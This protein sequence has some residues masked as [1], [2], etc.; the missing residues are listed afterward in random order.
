MNPVDNEYETEEAIGSSFKILN[1]TKLHL[2][3]FGSECLFQIQH[4]KNLED[5]CLGHGNYTQV[6]DDL[7]I[8][9]C[10][11][12]RFLKHVDISRKYITYQILKYPLIK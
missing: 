7:L 1:L 8:T 12:C 5:L 6:D 9:I 11:N 4:L 3:L 10:K 2:H